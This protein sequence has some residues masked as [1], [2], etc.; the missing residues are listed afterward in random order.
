MTC[1]TNGPGAAPLCVAR[2]SECANKQ[3]LVCMTMGP[4]RKRSFCVTANQ[5]RR[6]SH[7]P[8]KAKLPPDQQTLQ[9]LQ[10]QSLRNMNIQSP[11]PIPVSLSHPLPQPQRVSLSLCHPG[12][13]TTHSVDKTGLKLKDPPASASWELKSCATIPAPSHPWCP[14]PVRQEPGQAGGTALLQQL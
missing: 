6:C 5:A 3:T 9:A 14:S 13:P 7:P 11:L 2:L 12:S 10:C 1:G 8:G 4:T